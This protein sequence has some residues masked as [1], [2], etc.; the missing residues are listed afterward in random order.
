MPRIL[1]N[2]ARLVGSGYETTVRGDVP[3]FSP[4]FPSCLTNGVTSSGAVSEP[5]GTADGRKNSSLV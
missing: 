4:N 5:S 3:S 2:D 1:L